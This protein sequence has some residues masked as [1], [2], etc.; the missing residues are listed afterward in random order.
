MLKK[1]L[2]EQKGAVIVITALMATA[3][4]GF[5]ALAVDIGNLYLNKTQLAKEADAAAL[6]GA[7]DLPGDPSQAVVTAQSYAV[8]NGKAGDRVQASVND[9]NSIVSVTISRTVPLFFANAFNQLS[10]SAVSATAKAANK[11][12]T[13]VNG[14][15]PLGVEKQTLVYGQTYTLK[16]GGGDG[17]NG[18]YGALGLGGSGA[19]LYCYNL[20]QGYDG[21]LYVGQMVNTETGNMS[22]PT[23]SGLSYRLNQD[24]YATYETVQKDSPRIIVVPII[25]SF[26]VNGHKQ[27][28]IVGFAAFFLEGVGG[29]GNDNYVTGKFLK[30]YDMG[31][32][33]GAGTDYGLRNIRL[34]E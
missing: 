29:S 6:A 11:V 23:S 34:I 32:T 14:A 7:M 22:G 26:D 18:N 21:R 19:S 17:S 2:R 28:Q 20:Q 8:M 12:I 16:E 30:M 10:S 33:D 31:E 4:M 27:V 1:L 9:D 24:P 3:M 13:G 15:V 25:E 5:G